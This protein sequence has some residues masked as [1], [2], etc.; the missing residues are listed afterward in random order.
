MCHINKYVTAG[1]VTGSKSPG[2]MSVIPAQA[3]A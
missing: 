2:K 1:E 3:L